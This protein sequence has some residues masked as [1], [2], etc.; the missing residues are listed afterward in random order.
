MIKFLTSA[1]LAILSFIL[2]LKLKPVLGWTP[3]LFLVTLIAVSFYLKFS[4]FAT[5][6]LM[7]VWF[8]NWRPGIGWDMIFYAV[9]PIIV[10]FLFRFLPWQPLF[11]NLILGV[12]AITVF[13]LGTVG[14]SVLS[15]EKFIFLEDVFW[16]SL[17]GF[18]VFMILKSN[19][20]A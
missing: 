1:L 19:G 20:K 12:L 3:D 5:L 4:Q 11:I 10:F 17:F 9:I 6:L 7:G 16:S 2:Q 13:Y 18:A 8:L 15:R 14:Y